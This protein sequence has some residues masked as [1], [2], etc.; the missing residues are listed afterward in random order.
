TY[1][2][3][4]TDHAAHA[5]AE[6]YL[7]GFGWFPAEMTPGYYENQ[8]E[9]LE[10]IILD[11]DPEGEDVQVQDPQTDSSPEPDRQQNIPE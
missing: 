11:K 8:L 6:I 9:G 2:A 7:P 4:I 10:K 3:E 5:W 1:K